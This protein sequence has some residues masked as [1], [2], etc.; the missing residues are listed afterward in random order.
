MAGSVSDDDNR[1][2]RTC[3]PRER[4]VEARS[5]PKLTEERRPVRTPWTIALALM[6]AV[7]PALARSPHAAAKS[8]PAAPAFT[9]PGLQGDV[10][11]DSLRGKAVLV[12]F[13]ASW[14]GPCRQS[15][16][17]M[18]DLQHR[19]GAKG[20]AIVAVNLDKD[21]EFANTFLA[22][23][24]ASFTVAFDPSGRTAESY[25]VKAMP[26]TFLISPDGKL[27]VTHTGFDA[28]RA[29]EFEA[30]IAAALPR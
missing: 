21:R 20:L 19:Y 11:L 9:L 10:T 7:A 25:K 18:N 4:A 13:W 28:K 12:D 26:T 30:Q 2:D 8:S 24:P 6:L 14:C 1:A 29:P 5:R 3:V 22:E 17:W 15:F 27:L 16:P 23:V